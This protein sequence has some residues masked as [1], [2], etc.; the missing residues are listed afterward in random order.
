MT[1]TR[2]TVTRDIPGGIP[3]NRSL[4]TR[5]SKRTLGNRSRN[6]QLAFS[7]NLIQISLNKDTQQ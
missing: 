2:L 4:A 7:F 3:I 6:L 5:L 1:N